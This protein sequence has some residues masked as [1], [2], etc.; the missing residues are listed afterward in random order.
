VPGKKIIKLASLTILEDQSNDFKVSLV[1]PERLVPPV[2]RLLHRRVA[3][4]VVA[5]VALPPTQWPPH[6]PALL[7]HLPRRRLHLLPLP[8]QQMLLPLPQLRPLQPLTASSNWQGPS[9]T[10]PPILKLCPSLLKLSTSQFLSWT[11]RKI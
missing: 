4:E 8:P 10:N 11:S 5:V 2:V 7:R 9:S 3:V 1:L 6:P